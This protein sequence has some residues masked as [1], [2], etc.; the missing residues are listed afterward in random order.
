MNEFTWFALVFGLTYFVTAAQITARPRHFVF[1]LLGPHLG[2]WLACAPCSA[3]WVGCGV[4]PGYGL[5][6]STGWGL[7]PDHL[8]SG[9]LAMGVIAAFQFISHVPIAELAETEEKD[10]E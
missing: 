1:E 7:V 3:F 4:G 2:G 9:V 10:D 5:N 6:F 8:L